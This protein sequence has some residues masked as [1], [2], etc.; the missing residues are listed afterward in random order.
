MVSTYVMGLD[1]G[2][3]GEP[4]GFAVIERP[5]VE[6]RPAEPEYHLRHL[7][8]FPPGTPYPDIIEAVARRAGT[9]PLRGSPVIVDR[10]AVGKAIIDR[11]RRSKLA[12][13]MVV[14]G[15]GQDVQAADGGGL[16]V[17]KKELVTSLQLLLQ[18]RRL[19]VAPGLPEAEMLTAELAG[20]RLRRVPISETDATE[21][22]VGRHDDLVFAVAL[23]CWHADRHRPLGPG[24][25][26]VGG[27]E[28]SRLMFGGM[29]F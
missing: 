6:V 1:I 5:A 22:R 13:K 7:E 21:W 17:P 9:A 3:P 27:S 24:S 10:T 25:I 15:A 23:A 8:R 12:V 11:L 16:V 29:Q 26:G 20:F 4:T 2:P 18:G 28:L 19:K 14:I